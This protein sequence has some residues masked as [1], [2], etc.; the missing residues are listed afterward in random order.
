MAHANEK[1]VVIGETTHGGLSALSRSFNGSVMDYGSLIQSTLQRAATAREAISTIADLCNTYGYSSNMEG[2]SIAGPGPDGAEAW[3]M[4]LIGKGTHGKGIVWVALKVPDGYIT[5]HANQARITTFLPC[6]PENCMAAPDA[7][8]FA[9]EHGFFKGKADDPNFSFSDT[10]DPVTSSGARSCEARV[11]YIFRMADPEDFDAE[12]YLSYAQGFNLTKRMPLFVRPKKKLTRATIH[13]MLGSHYEGSFFDPTKDVGA[14]AEHTPYRWN[15]HW[16]VDGKHYL[17]ERVIGTQATAWHYVAQVKGGAVPAPMRAL[18]W[19]GADDHAWAP[20]VPL[21]CGATAVDRTYDDGNCSARLACRRALGLPGSMMEFSWD[22]AWWVNSAVAKMVYTEKDRAAPAV[23][24]AQRA[25]DDW[26]VAKVAAAAAAARSRFDA[27]DAAGGVTVL[28]DLAT[29]ASKEAT[30]RWTKLWQSLTV[31]F[32]DGVTATR[33]DSNLICGCKKSGTTFSDAWLK[34]V[35]VDTGDRYRAP[36]SSCAGYDKDGHCR[37]KEDDS[38]EE[39]AQPV[40]IPKHL[41]SGV[42]D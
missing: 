15:G 37:P 8:T 18:V 12:D 35:V 33:D 16:S 20:K 6:K 11:W 38:P 3:Y 7:V 29:E 19:F 21:Y 23:E 1:G 14:G 22:D 2:F 31:T 32:N 30:A 40:A 26:A 24:S 36:D 13:A 41:V 25:F 42:F 10:Y 28:T 17:N 4:E 27:G 9:I 39:P 5:A 34:K